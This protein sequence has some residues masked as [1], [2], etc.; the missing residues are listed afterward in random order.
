MNKDN[1]KTVNWDSI[2]KANDYSSHADS[3][4]NKMRYQDTFKTEFYG[5][6]VEGQNVDN[7]Q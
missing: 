7:Q 2:A 1:F 4:E 3:V 5:S 6:D